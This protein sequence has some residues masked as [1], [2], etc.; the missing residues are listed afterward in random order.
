MI[1]LVDPKINKKLNFETKINKSLSKT[2][3]EYNGEDFL[4]KRNYFGK[5]TNFGE[6]LYSN[7]CKKLNI[8]CV[9]ATIVNFEGDTFFLE[10]DGVMVKSFL[11]DD[12]LFVLNYYDM[13]ELNNVSDK[14]KHYTY[15]DECLKNIKK[16]ADNIRYDFNV[17]EVR[18]ELYKRTILD[19]FLA[20]TDRHWRNFEFIVYKDK[21]ILAP[22]FDNGMCLSFNN[23]K[24]YNKDIIQNFYQCFENPYFFSE[25]EF[26]LYKN[27]KK[28]EK[29]FVG[30][31]FCDKFTKQ[32]VSICKRNKEIQS[33]VNK[34]LNINIED[35]MEKVEKQQGFELD[36]LFK[37][38]SKEIFEKRVGLFKENFNKAQ[39]QSRKG[40]IKE[41][42]KTTS[43]DKIQVL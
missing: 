41:D 30:Y 25:N 20:Q 40:K 29:H 11:N 24:Q 8:E 32:L 17:K 19:F 22:M 39:I 35:E 13:I 18:K 26:F 28:N 7:L 27:Y 23:D 2:W 31:E 33:F 43:K 4:F 3:L 42:N 12:M 9:Q 15:V 21:L 38:S 14:K 16:Y 5:R 1:K 34:I 37:I 6:V 36:E 10:D